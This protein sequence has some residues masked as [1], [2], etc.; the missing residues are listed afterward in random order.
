MRL[1]EELDFT[2]LI[3]KKRHNYEVKILSAVLEHYNFTD[4]D[5]DKLTVDYE[6]V[7]NYSTSILTVRYK[8]QLIYRRFPLDLGGVKYRYEAPI[9]NNV[10]EPK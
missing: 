1:K 5:V 7:K 2:E 8:G 9:F 6:R 3:Y 10:S 4:Y